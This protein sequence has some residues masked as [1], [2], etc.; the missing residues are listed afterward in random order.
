MI[1]APSSQG[2]RPLV[3]T[4]TNPLNAND[5]NYGVRSLHRR[6]SLTVS[7]PSIYFS[8][9]ETESTSVLTETEG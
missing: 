7:V 4:K 3:R 6:F 5:F 8:V 2:A 1:R 9:R